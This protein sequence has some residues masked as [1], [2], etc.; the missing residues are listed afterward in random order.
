MSEAET[1]PRREGEA[2]RIRGVV[3]TAG[4]T[5]RSKLNDAPCVYWDVRVGLA[6]EPEA[7]DVCTFWVEDEGGE[8]F[9]VRVDALEVDVR[10]QRAESLVQLVEEDI[11]AVSATIRA[12]KETAKHGPLAQQGEANRER[13]RLAKVAT[14]LCAV[15]AEARGNV[16]VGGDLAGQRKWIAAHVHIATNEAGRSLQRREERFEVVLREGDSVEVSGVLRREPLPSGLGGGYRER[17]DCWAMAPGA[18]GHVRVVG[19]GASAPV[20]EAELR[21]KQTAGRDPSLPHTWPKLDP[22]LV[23]VIGVSALLSALAHALD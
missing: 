10:A 6:D 11:I 20:P 2:S 18:S 12:L 23:V 3:R 15:R 19:V 8:R 14:L 17:T 21:P 1:S 22:V 13:R 5:L 16:H 4:Q 9:L 7:T